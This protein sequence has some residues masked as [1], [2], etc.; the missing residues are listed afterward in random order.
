M[1]NTTDIRE[2]D[3]RKICNQELL[4]LFP[5]PSNEQI[6]RL[7][8]ELRQIQGLQMEIT[9]LYSY[10]LAQMVKEDGGLIGPSS[11]SSSGSFVLY[12]L[13]V[14]MVNPIEYGLLFEHFFPVDRFK[15]IK[16]G[17]EIDM[18]SL[19]HIRHNLTNSLFLIDNIQI[20]DPLLCN[21]FELSIDGNTIQLEGSKILTELLKTQK[22]NV[23][24]SIDFEKIALDDQGIFQKLA[25]NN[26]IVNIQ[27]ID[28]G[29]L[30][31]YTTEQDEFLNK[32]APISIEE[33]AQ[34]LVY[35]KPWCDYDLKSILKRKNGEK[36][37][38]RFQEKYFGETN[39]IYTF[40][41]QVSIMLQNYLGF[42][43][44]QVVIYQKPIRKSVPKLKNVSEEMFFYYG[45]EHE[46]DR[47]DLEQIWYNMM[48]Y[49]SSMTD[50]SRIIGEA[51]TL[52]YAT[53][54]LLKE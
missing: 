33:L 2:Q 43:K 4:E 54:L 12:L 17:M 35:L 26:E 34:V 1:K 48:H 46:Y 29:F 30:A 5:E 41:E 53:Y 14:S 10:Q 44:A 51:L 15:N 37:L 8:F 13:G 28:S 31:G 23:D 20:E 7:D 22:A 52:Y 27:K 49:N 24:M 32:F 25:S 38:T 42:R 45:R 50:K 21:V 18:D 47:I 19:E 39:G 36:D 3:L 16:I 11:V 40:P 9:F 6:D